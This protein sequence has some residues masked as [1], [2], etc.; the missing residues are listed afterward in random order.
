MVARWV[1]IPK[2]A[3]STPASATKNK[4]R[5]T[6]INKI[7]EALRQE[8]K[9]RLELDDERLDGVAAFAAT[10]VTDES[11]IEEFVKNEA[12][13]AML[14]SYQSVADKAV[15]KAMSKGETKSETS[16]TVEKPEEKVEQPSGEMAE[17][18]KLMKEQNAALQQQ[19]AALTAR[20]DAF[21]AAQNAKSAFANAEALFKG[22]DYVK[23]Y[24]EEAND[25]WERATEMYEALGKTWTE[26]EL[27]DKAWGYFTKAV[28][29]K[30]IDTSKPFESDGGGND[31]KGLETDKIVEA[32]KSGGNWPVN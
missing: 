26:K 27:H 22:D 21:E 32:L 17:L 20:F 9:S 19:N 11:K 12:T 23:K 28:G 25:S 2:V 30:G 29:K 16:E 10:F 14:K 18:I 15:T 1:H 31:D 6:M 8:Y 24:A 7:K 3:G 5:I 13:L 4:F